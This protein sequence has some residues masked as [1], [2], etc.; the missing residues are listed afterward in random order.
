MMKQNIIY[1]V[2]AGFA[3]LLV[4]ACTEILEIAP[5]SSISVASFWESPDDARGG[6]AGMYK[7]LREFDYDLYMMGV[8]RSEIMSGET[9]GRNPD[10]RIKYFENTLSAANA[11]MGWQKPYQIVSTANLIIANLPEIDFPNESEKNDMLAQAHSM[12]AFIYFVLART[13]GDV[14]LIEDPIVDF[15]PE[16][17]FRKRDPVQQIFDLIKGDIDTAL[18]LYPDNEFPAG[19]STWSKPAANMLKGKVYLWTGKR[20][21]G[22]QQDFT[23]ALSALEEAETADLRLLDD[24]SDIFDYDNKGNE[25]IVLAIHFDGLEGGNSFYVDM[26]PLIAAINNTNEETQ[27]LL[28][29]GGEGWWA[30]STYAI[31]QFNEDDLRK[32]ATFY[33]LYS[34]EDSTFITTG[35]TKFNG[36]VEGSTRRFIDDIIIYR[37]GG[38]L[39]AKAEAKSALGQDP[40]PEINMIR[41][42]GYGENFDE[43]VFVSSSQEENDN[44]ILQERLFELGWEG[45]RWWDLVRFGKVYELVPSLQGR[46]NEIPTLFPLDE[47]TMT[48]NSSLTQTIGY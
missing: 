37:Y 35:V 9:S 1:R 4:S 20:M 40:S 2:I 19:R 39:L 15:D 6:L 33:Q 47:E 48:R 41:E 5:I 26:Y 29:P 8:A 36:L 21:G 28:S 7:Q 12:R 23:T 24:Y 25:E 32:E 14:P 27:A 46:E 11:D 34:A 18:S 22:G 17:T 45:T 38:L 16:V 44:A 31:N 13:W 10:W 30:P 43:H 42:R 3:L